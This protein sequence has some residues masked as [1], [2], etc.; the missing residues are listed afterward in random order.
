MRPLTT[1]GSDASVK[2]DELILSW[3][4]SE[5][6]PPTTELDALIHGNHWHNYHLWN[7]EDIVRIPEISDLEVRQAKN[8]IDYHNHIRNQ[9]VERIDNLLYGLFT[10]KPSCAINSETPGMIIDRLSILALKVYN[11]SLKGVTNQAIQIAAYRDNLS[12]RLNELISDIYSGKRF[13]ELSHAFK[14]YENPY[15]L[16]REKQSS[17]PL[18]LSP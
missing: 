16:C 3:V 4:R 18:K 14:L 7:L 2:H 17:P 6:I 12:L 1:L 9:L 8:G 11:S 5:E 13:F 10:R 15:V